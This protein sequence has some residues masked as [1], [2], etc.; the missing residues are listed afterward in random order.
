[1]SVYIIIFLASSLISAFSQI[2]LKI[3]ARRKYSSWIFEYLNVRVI[4]AYA[5]FFLATLLT[6]YCYKVVPLSVGAMLEASGYVFVTVLGRIILREKIS[7]QKLLGMALVIS[8][9]II[10]AV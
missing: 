6:V 7:K 9:V 5:I 1:M 8:G 2:L 10:V 3:A 4:S